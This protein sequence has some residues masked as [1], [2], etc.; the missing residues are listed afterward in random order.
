MILPPNTT[1]KFYFLETENKIRK[2]QKKKVIFMCHVDDD[3]EIIYNEIKYVIKLS[4]LKGQK[5][6]INT[7]FRKNF[8]KQLFLKFFLNI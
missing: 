6:K 4:K 2:Q 1:F 5:T 7:H 8:K 3:A